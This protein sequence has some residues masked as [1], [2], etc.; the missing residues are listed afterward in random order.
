MYSWIFNENKIK[1]PTDSICCY[2]I[3]VSP[4]LSILS[5][6]RFYWLHSHEFV[7]AWA[8]DRNIASH[9]FV[10]TSLILCT[11]FLLPRSS[12][13]APVLC[14]VLYYTLWGR[15]TFFSIF[16]PVITA[17]IRHIW[18]CW[19]DVSDKREARCRAVNWG[20]RVNE[21]VKTTLCKVFFLDSRNL[22]SRSIAGLVGS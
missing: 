18:L 15:Q 9:S 3:K 1:K 11:S 2:L 8:Q 5:K 19:D 7:S 13:W 21:H 6:E 14:Q 22:E 12:Y 4:S 16:P 10:I 17:S 20:A